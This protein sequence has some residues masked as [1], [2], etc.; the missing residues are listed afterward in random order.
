VTVLGIPGIGLLGHLEELRAN[1]RL[2]AFALILLWL[3]PLVLLLV[4]ARIWL[5]ANC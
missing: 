2:I 5:M 4:L 1:L 3:L